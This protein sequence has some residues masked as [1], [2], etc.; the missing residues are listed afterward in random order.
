MQYS[1]EDLQNAVN[2]VNSGMSLNAVS[3]KYNIPR[4]TLSTKVN[5]K[6]ADKKPGPAPILSESEET[7]L[8][9]WIIQ[10][11]NTAA[12]VTKEQLLN[13]VQS[14]VRGRENPFTDD[15]PRRGLSKGFMKCHGQQ[16]RE[17]VSE[18]STL[19][20]KKTSQGAI[21]KWC[22]A[23]NS[24]D[25]TNYEPSRIFNCDEIASPLNPKKGFAEV[26][27]GS[28]IVHNTVSDENEC[29]ATFIMVNAAGV[30]APPLTIFF[31][32][33]AHCSGSPSWNMILQQMDG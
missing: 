6:Y 9:N 18:L 7:A 29:I 1:T 31:S 11:S 4:S 33:A 19:H 12:P 25:L 13:S 30:L 8:V 2:C 16:L 22:S 14:T 24:K 32:A 23:L 10:R 21:R 28:T 27:K 26:E 15:R 17:K 20:T 5:R 3:S